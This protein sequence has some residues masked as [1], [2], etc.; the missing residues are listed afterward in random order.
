MIC[1]NIHS[2]AINKKKL[3]RIAGINQDN[4]CWDTQLGE[5][6]NQIY[7]RLSSEQKP[8]GVG[9]KHDQAGAG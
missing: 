8:K 4:K 3:L 5:I 1:L 7:W 9:G 2:L 6:V